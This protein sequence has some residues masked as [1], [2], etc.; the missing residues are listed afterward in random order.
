MKFVVISDLHIGGAFNEDIFYKGV[1]Y[2]NSIEAD[3]YI[4]AGD[5]TDKGTLSEYNIALNKYLPLIKKPLLIVP[6]NHDVKNS[7]FLIYEEL[8]G[9]RHFLETDE[10][11]KVKIIG[12]DSNVPDRNTGSMGAFAMEFI[13]DNFQH[14][15]DNWLKVLVFHHQTLPIKYTGRERS[16]L[17]DAGDVIKAVNDNNVDLVINGHRHISNVYRLTDGDIK[18]L[19]VNCGTLSCKKT[20]YREEYSITQIEISDNQE[21]AEVDVLLLNHDPPVWKKAFSGSIKEIPYKS[22]KSYELLSTIIQIGNT[23]FSDN[24]LNI[25]NYLQLTQLINSLDTC[26]VVIHTGNVTGHSYEHEYEMG[27]IMLGQIHKPKLIIPGPRDYFPIGIDLFEEF[28][29]KLNPEYEDNKLK[30]LGFDTCILEEKIGRLGRGR[31]SQLIQKLNHSLEKIGIVALHH[32]I[33][34]LARTKHES[35]LQDAGDLLSAMVENNVNLVLSGAKNKAG[36]W[37]VN[38][39]IFVNAGTMSSKNIISRKGNS[40]NIIK[41]FKTPIGKLYDIS[42]YFI[43]SNEMDSLGKFHIKDEDRSNFISAYDIPD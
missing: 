28:I 16:A 41:V 27:K 13:Y 3:Y 42:E 29:G 35:E 10:E 36:A 15:D 21:H 14:L 11:K 4:M 40:I 6:G 24:L 1:E 37:Q 19:I 38:N 32:N 34:P 30:V 39:T 12:L 9:P 5:L 17:V 23:H 25:D 8:I 18:T 31:T 20:R 43:D 26:D 7:G 33:V 2:I 22:E